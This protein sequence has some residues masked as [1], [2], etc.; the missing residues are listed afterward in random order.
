MKAAVGIYV[1]AKYVLKNAIKTALTIN[2]F[3]MKVVKEREV[4]GVKHSPM[5]QMIQLS[6]A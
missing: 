3:H 5:T 6:I 1:Y 2:C 4:G